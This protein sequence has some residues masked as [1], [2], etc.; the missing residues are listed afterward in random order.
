MS[1]DALHEAGFARR[2]RIS[3][4]EMEQRRTDRHFAIAL[5]A[6]LS[7]KTEAE[8]QHKYQ[9]MTQLMDEVRP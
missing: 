2:I 8:A 5:I 7:S 3:K 1:E 6:G 4:R 9:W